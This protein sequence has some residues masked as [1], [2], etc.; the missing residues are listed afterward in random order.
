MAFMER[1]HSEMADLLTD[2]C[3][4]VRIIAV[5]VYYIR[6]LTYVLHV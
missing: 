1:Q 3:H 6:L 4:I 5:K 2:N